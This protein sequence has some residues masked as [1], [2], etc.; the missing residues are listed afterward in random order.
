V[1]SKVLFGLLG[2]IFN[3]FLMKIFDKI[4]KRWKRQNVYYIYVEYDH[5]GGHIGHDH[6]CW[7][8]SV[9][10]YVDRVVTISNAHWRPWINT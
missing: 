3:E 9:A 2:G 5:A 1:A 10:S 8:P 7:H 4:K 6:E